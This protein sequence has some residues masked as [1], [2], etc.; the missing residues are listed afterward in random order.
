MHR[1]RS[2]EFAFSLLMALVAAPLAAQAPP[3]RALHVHRGGI[4][5]DR[6]VFD[7]AGDGVLRA[8]AR[9]YKMEFAAGR[10]T[11]V[12][13][14][15]SAAPRDFPIAFALAAGRCGE[16]V[17]PI[18]GDGA[19]HR[20]DARVE[21]PHGAVVEA[22]DLELDGAEQS[23][24][25]ATRPG[26]G[27][28]RLDLRV[29][30]ELAIL[31]DGEGVRFAN[32]H[33]AASYGAAT[34]VDADGMRTPVDLGLT[35]DGIALEVPAATLAGAAFPIVI[36]PYVQTH[37]VANSTYNEHSIDCAYDASTDQWMATWEGDSSATNHDIGCALLDSTGLMIPGSFQFIDSSA[38]NYERP[39]IAVNNYT[40]TF[41]IVAMKLGPAGHEVWVRT[42]NN[43]NLGTPVLVSTLLTESV[44]PD[45]GGD[46]SASIDNP[47]LVVWQQAPAAPGG[48]WVVHSRLVGADSSL[49]SNDTPIG[50]AD[51]VARHTSVAKSCGT[52]SGLGQYWPVVWSWPRNI[53]ATGQIWGAI[54]RA[55]GAVPGGPSQWGSIQG[56]GSSEPAVSSPTDPIGNQRY[57]V[58][59]YSD[60]VSGFQHLFA[61]VRSLQGAVT[62]AADIQSVVGLGN[63]T[64][65]TTPTLDTFGARFAVAYSQQSLFFPSDI[66]VATLDLRSSGTGLHLG[67]VEGS[68]LMSN[69]TQ[70]SPAHGNPHI[71]SARSG[72]GGEPTIPPRHLIT[73]EQNG[74]VLAGTYDGY[75]PTGGYSVVPTGCGGLGIYG[76]GIPHAGNYIAGGLLGTN[77][78]TTFVCIGLPAAVTQPLC[79]S[80]LIGLDLSWLSVVGG[81]SISIPL[82]PIG[83]LNGLT[84]AVQGVAIGTSTCYGLVRLGDTLHATLR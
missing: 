56:F 21:L 45:I 42:W 57:F 39:K 67:R 64:T 20:R 79:G 2:P 27:D 28:L 4:P 58:F 52:E 10:A 55:D 54:V 43:G 48:Q 9:G 23:F 19:P 25:L 15:G 53:L 40:H 61:G 41:M 24:V 6:V 77:G 34:M 35:A 1:S 81:P 44:H 32:E 47:F 75:A 68:I 14:F 38:W 80:C 30:S 70:T 74:D 76:V 22:W 33:G 59:A 29:T 62:A 71:C 7:D 63:S 17:L 8:V 65:V 66:G 72:G 46:P 60:D 73:W 16:R 50:L 84:L 3:A 18:A 31:R 26:A 36:D 37:W 69:S 49:Q 5:V 12:P 82:P 11:Y 83:G 13:F 51:T 78:E